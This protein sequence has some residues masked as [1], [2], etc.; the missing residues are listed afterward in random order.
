MNSFSLEVEKSL[1]DRSLPL[2]CYK[3]APAQIQLETGSGRGWG[4]DNGLSSGEADATE[5]RVVDAPTS[6]LSLNVGIFCVSNNLSRTTSL[7]ASLSAP[8]SSPSNYGAPIGD[9]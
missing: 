2:S 4:F 1:R 8:S 9:S 3:L 7:G 6:L 5:E